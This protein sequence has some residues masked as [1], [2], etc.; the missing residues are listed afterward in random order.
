MCHRLFNSRAAA[1]EIYLKIY[2]Q[3]QAKWIADAST[4]IL[5]RLK[6]C[7]KLVLIVNTDGKPSR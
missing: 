7:L 4:A 5:N 6:R 2:F 1:S 3:R